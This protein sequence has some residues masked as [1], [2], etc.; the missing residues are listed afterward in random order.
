MTICGQNGEFLVEAH[1]FKGISD[2]INNLFELLL[3]LTLLGPG[4]LQI[5]K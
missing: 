5:M 4:L 3:A 2:F 1:G